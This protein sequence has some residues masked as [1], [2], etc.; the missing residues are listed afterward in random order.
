MLDPLC[1][2]FEDEPMHATVPGYIQYV[3]TDVVLKSDRREIVT[4]VL[5]SSGGFDMSFHQYEGA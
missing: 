5:L 4:K 1:V 2:L 3:G